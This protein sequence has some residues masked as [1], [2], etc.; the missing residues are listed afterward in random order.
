SKIT[1][2][3]KVCKIN[4]TKKDMILFKFSSSVLS[5]TKFFASTENK[6]SKVQRP[7]RTE[8][9]NVNLTLMTSKSEQKDLVCHVRKA[10][11]SDLGEILRIILTE[12]RFRM[13][14]LVPTVFF[15]GLVFGSI[16]T[17]AILAIG[18]LTVIT[19]IQKQAHSTMMYI[20]AVLIPALIIYIFGLI[21]AY[22]QINIRYNKIAKLKELGISSFNELDS[23]FESHSIYMAFECEKKKTEEASSVVKKKTKVNAWDVIYEALL[24]YICG[25]NKIASNDCGS[26]DENNAN[27]ILCVSD[28]M[29]TWQHQCLLQNGFVLCGKWEDL[30][31]CGVSF[32]TKYYFFNKPIHHPH[33][34]AIKDKKLFQTSKKI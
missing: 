8:E 31:L 15:N 23:F 5:V 17:M 9:K 22:K 34:P 21:K 2:Y 3:I 29:L 14:D 19:I 32:P 4:Y 1:V 6:T 7:R 16:V 28:N 25:N 30:H 12:P 26:L 13:V 20:T 11:Q 27:Y 10:K 18:I 24:E 33:L